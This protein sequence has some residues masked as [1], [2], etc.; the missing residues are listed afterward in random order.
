MIKKLA[1]FLALCYGFLFACPVMASS[2]DAA[3]THPLNEFRVELVNEKGWDIFLDSK[4]RRVTLPPGNYQLNYTYLIKKDRQ[5]N[6]WRIQPGN[7]GKFI[8]LGAG[9]N[10]V[11]PYREPFKVELEVTPQLFSYKIKDRTS[12][13]FIYIYKNDDLAEP[14][15]FRVYDLKGKEILSGRFSYG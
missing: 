5:G 13:E 9:E 15:P 1:V 14:F 10:H 6:T 11:L 7:I 8:N 2:K 3:L 12:Q 4:N